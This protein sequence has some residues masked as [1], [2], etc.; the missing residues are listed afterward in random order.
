MLYFVLECRYMVIWVTHYFVIFCLDC[1][2]NCIKDLSAEI[3]ANKGNK[4]KW[5][6]V[7]NYLE[8]KVSS[9]FFSNNF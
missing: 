4:Y 8:K 2:D 5:F 1:I 6:S 3:N 7:F 9:I